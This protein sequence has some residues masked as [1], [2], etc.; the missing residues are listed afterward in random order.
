MEETQLSGDCF[1][2]QAEI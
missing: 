1:I 2:T